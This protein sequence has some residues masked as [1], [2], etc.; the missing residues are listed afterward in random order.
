MLALFVAVV[1]VLIVLWDQL[2]VMAL[3][4]VTVGATWAIAQS[5]RRWWFW[6]VLILAALLVMAA[7]VVAVLIS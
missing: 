5:E 3:G 6:P 1:L 4:G 2:V 7:F